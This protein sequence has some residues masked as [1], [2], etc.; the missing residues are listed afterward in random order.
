MQSLASTCVANRVGGKLHVSAS[1]VIFFCGRFVPGRYVTRTQE[2]AQG[3]PLRFANNAEKK[4][5]V[6]MKKKLVI[7]A[8][9][10]GAALL[11]SGAVALAD[12]AAPGPDPKG[13]KCWGE[14]DTGYLHWAYTPCGWTYS[15]DNG[16][17]QAPP[18]PNP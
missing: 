2:P 5:N 13:P 14:N 15:D 11:S 18:P 1:A 17:Q 4:K 10:L 9:A 12:P 7:A 3:R 16:W 6:S 8:A